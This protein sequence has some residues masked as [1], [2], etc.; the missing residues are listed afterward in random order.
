MGGCSSAYPG[1]HVHPGTSEQL[2][3]SDTYTHTSFP[4][5]FHRSVPR[6]RS[7]SLGTSRVRAA[8][9]GCSNW[10]C[11]L[12]PR[13]GRLLEGLSHRLE[14]GSCREPPACSRIHPLHK[15]GARVSGETLV[16]GLWEKRGGFTTV[17]F[18]KLRNANSCFLHE[19][20]SWANK[21]LVDPI[22]I[23]LN[24]LDVH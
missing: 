14:A 2:W 18:A 13:G 7:T 1:C 23:T 20:S 22:V 8:N 11:V 6:F 10:R 16:P 12:L 17:L 21:L 9:P 4:Q 3:L 5:C 15:W 24:E 19:F